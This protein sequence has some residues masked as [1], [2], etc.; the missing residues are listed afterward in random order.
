M[1]RANWEN[2]F[3]DTL[4]DWHRWVDD[5]KGA[6]FFGAPVKE[7]EREG[8]LAIIGHMQEILLK[9][10]EQHTRELGILDEIRD[11]VKNK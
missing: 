8:L 9:Q 1:T 7:F 4:P 5:A 6:T 11:A 2:M 10:L 3:C